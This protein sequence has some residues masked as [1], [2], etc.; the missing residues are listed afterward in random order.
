M[1]SKN[2]YKRNVEEEIIMKYKCKI[3]GWTKENDPMMHIT[4]KMLK[5]ISAHDNSHKEHND[6]GIPRNRG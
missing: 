2:E 4:T 1:H 5:E 3:C 6:R